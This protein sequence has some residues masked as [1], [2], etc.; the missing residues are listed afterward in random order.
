MNYHRA[1]K[2]TFFTIILLALQQSS[3][4]QKLKIKPY[5]SL[6]AQAGIYKENGISGGADVNV[7]VY[8]G[9]KLGLGAGIEMLKLK[10]MR[11]FYYPVYLDIKSFTN[12]GTK[13]Q[14]L[15]SLQ[16]GFG[17]YYYN[18]TF[19]FNHFRN[20]GGFYFGSGLGLKF[21][22]ALELSDKIKLSPIIYLRYNLYQ[23]KTYVVG[24]VYNGDVSDNINTCTLNI[25]F[26]L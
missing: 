2:L 23:F 22:Q 11:K 6:T 1:I 25:G 14:V 3:F 16:P 26:A 24:N 18:E 10:D 4:S 12:L 17:H 20:K 5:G 13:Y 19:L 9:G 7:G 15:F 21:N 8:L